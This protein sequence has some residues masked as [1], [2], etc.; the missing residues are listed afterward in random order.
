[1]RKKMI[2]GHKT[3][4]KVPSFITPTASDALKYEKYFVQTGKWLSVN[5]YIH[6]ETILVKEEGG[7]PDGMF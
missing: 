7:D 1:M 2:W 4:I 3:S 5:E 6:E